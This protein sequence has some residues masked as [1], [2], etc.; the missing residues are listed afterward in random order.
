MEE[1]LTWP[2]EEVSDEV[3]TAQ[4][5]ACEWYGAVL[6]GTSRCQTVTYCTKVSV[7][8]DIWMYQCM[9]VCTQSI[10]QKYHINSM[11]AGHPFILSWIFM[12]AHALCTSLQVQCLKWLQDWRDDNISQSS[13]GICWVRLE[14]TLLSTS[15]ISSPACRHLLSLSSAVS[16]SLCSLY[17]SLHH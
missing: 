16:L 11:T 12:I 3:C 15:S 2:A 9:R 5:I 6:R 8:G 7:P 1:S 10:L 14:L 4:A 13:S 17:L